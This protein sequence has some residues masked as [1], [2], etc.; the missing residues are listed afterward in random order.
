MPLLSPSSCLFTLLIILIIAWLQRREQKLAA[1]KEKISKEKHELELEY[2][3]YRESQRNKA[4]LMTEYTRMMGDFNRSVA[5]N[6]HDFKRMAIMERKRALEE[7]PPL[8]LRAIEEVAWQEENM[9]PAEHVEALPGS[10]E[11]YSWRE[12]YRIAEQVSGQGMSLLGGACPL[13]RA[14]AHIISLSGLQEPG[15]ACCPT[16]H[17][18]T[19]C[20]ASRRSFSIGG[21]R[22]ATCNGRT[23]PSM[24]SSNS[25]TRR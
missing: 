23:R 15:A 6:K 11:V 2:L 9:Q 5:G 3:A 16:T 14:R 20:P 24:P 4:P 8:I 13:V 7:T 17:T 22:S 10:V 19:L 12:D 25:A 18:P 21:T 1:E